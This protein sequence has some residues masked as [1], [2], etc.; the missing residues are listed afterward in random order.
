MNITG[1]IRIVCISNTVRCHV[2]V[3]W[4]RMQLHLYITSRNFVMYTKWIVENISFVNITLNVHI[5]IIT[6]IRKYKWIQ[7]RCSKA[8]WKNTCVPSITAVIWLD[9]SGNV[10]K[11]LPTPITNCVLNVFSSLEGCGIADTTFI[12]FDIL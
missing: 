6:D 8:N 2:I 1:R 3:R 12:Y 11:L 4:Q 9:Y 10:V 5:N 7:S